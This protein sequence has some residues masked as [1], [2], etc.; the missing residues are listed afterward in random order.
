MHVSWPWFRY[1]YNSYRTR[2]MCCCGAQWLLAVHFKS[3]PHLGVKASCKVQ[4]GF[5]N[6]QTCASAQASDRL[7]K[8]N[9]SS[10]NIS[11]KECTDQ[12]TE[13]EKAFVLVMFYFSWLISSIF[14]SILT[15]S[16]YWVSLSLL[17][18]LILQGVCSFC[19]SGEHKASEQ[20][21][22]SFSFFHLPPS[23]FTFFSFIVHPPKLRLS[24]NFHFPGN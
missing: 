1:D 19:F 24:Q 23:I 4:D 16:L 22:L 15:L 14:F 11:V 6:N 9:G 13:G 21:L 18:H 3:K 17:F 20:C 2:L 7:V 8:L 12:N 10:H 5:L